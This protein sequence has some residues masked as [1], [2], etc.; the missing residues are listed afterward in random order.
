MAQNLGYAFY[1]DIYTISPNGIETETGKLK[2]L[3]A[4]KLPARQETLTKNNFSLFTTYPGLIMGVGLTHGV[5]D[6][7]DFKIGFSF[8]HTTGQPVIP[9][10][11]VK[12]LL[13]SV[14]PN[15]EKDRHVKLVKAAWIH[16]LINGIN[17]PDFYSKYYEPDVDKLIQADI[18]NVTNL[19]KEIFDGVKDGEI[20]G[21][22]QRDLFHDAWIASTNKRFLGTDY[23]TPHYPDLLR[24]PVPV[25]FLKI[26]PDIEIFFQFDL[27]PNKSLTVDKRLKLFKKI[28]LTIGIGAKTNVGYG[29]FVLNIGVQNAHGNTPSKLNQ[30]I[31]LKDLKVGDVIDARIADLSSAIVVELD[32][33]DITFKPR[34]TG[35]STRGYVKNQVI[36][37]KIEQIGKLMKFCMAPPK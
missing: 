12:G 36:K 2:T 1:K 20:M 7:H 35:I 34:L 9:G 33:K 28:L 6:D 19:E 14:F 3:L 27:K 21:I 25:K 15:A 22:Y 26:L 23:I 5:K 10:S 24:N 37:V 13:R 4:S 31:I 30:G 32:I 11:S 29:Q 8:D 18:D 17:D 16:A